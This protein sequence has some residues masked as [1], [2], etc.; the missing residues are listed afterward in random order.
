MRLFEHYITELRDQHALGAGVKELTYYP[1]L[2]NLL[3]G[4]GKTLTPQVRCV[5]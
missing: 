3:N 5:M 2:Y 4:I 1:P